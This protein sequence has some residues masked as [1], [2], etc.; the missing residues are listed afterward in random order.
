MFFRLNRFERLFTPWIGIILVCV[1]LFVRAIPCKN[2][3]IFGC[4][5][6]SGG[7]HLAEQPSSIRT[8]SESNQSARTRLTPWLGFFGVLAFGLAGLGLSRTANLPLEVIPG[9]WPG[10]N[11]ILVVV[12]ALAAG[13]IFTITFSAIGAIIRRP[14][15]DYVLASRLISPPLAFASSW[16]FVIAICLFAGGVAGSVARQLL[17]YSIKTL[18]TVFRMQELLP[19]AEASATAKV[20]I[21]VGT[22]IVIVAF[23]TLTMPPKTLSALFNIGFM[24]VIISWVILFYQLISSQGISF[25]ASYDR[26]FGSGTYAQQ[27]E[28]AYQYGLDTG[29]PGANI[30]VLVGLFSGFFLFFGA[31]LS[32][33]TSSEVVK[34]GKSLIPG[35][36]IALLVGGGLILAVVLL[37]QKVVPIQFL[38]AQSYLSQKQIEISGLA[39][40]WLPFYAA[41]AKPSIWMVVTICV[42][43]VYLLFLM[44]QALMF[45]V[46]RIVLAWS[47]DMLLPERIAFIHPRQQT[48]TLAVLIAAIAIQVGLIDTAQ[49][50]A[51]LSSMHLAVFLSV[52]QLLPVAAL[53]MIPILKQKGS[54]IHSPGPIRQG[55]IGFTGL[56][57]L[58]YLI[59]T[60]AAIFIYPFRLQEIK[61]TTFIL[62]GICIASGVGWY[63]LR[64]WWLRRRG[65]S[66]E[67]QFLSMPPEG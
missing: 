8:A 25:T 65:I 64:R 16:T 58:A 54:E 19:M 18:G 11:L 13:L 37:L 23:L 7:A 61:L 9:R 62:L 66:L 38:A 15:P 6:I 51:I 53:V 47:R 27:V 63:Y 5:F 67:E 46:S 40:P 29:V 22:V 2:Q 45:V 43:W 55:L 14:A 17:P 35:S 12:I 57:T 32:A 28:L 20:A 52:T 36:V 1:K 31:A 26:V 21:L 34:P 10:I 48:P 4:D 56:V 42:S 44:V 24:L 50:G 49:S 3:H 60:I 59:W 39:L 41:L 30:I 33:Q